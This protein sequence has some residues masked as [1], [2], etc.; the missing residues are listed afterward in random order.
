MRSKSGVLP[1]KDEVETAMQRILEAAKRNRVPCGLH[2]LTAEDALRRAEQGFQFI[3]VGS[4]LK[5]MLDS[6]TAAVRLTNPGEAGED[7]AKY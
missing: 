4:E 6:S 5:F 3:A 7:I 2:V 1:S